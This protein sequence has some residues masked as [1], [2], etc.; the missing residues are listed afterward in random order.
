MNCIISIGRSA[1]AKLWTVHKNTAQHLKPHGLDELAQS[2]KLHATLIIVAC[3]TVAAFLIAPINGTQYLEEARNELDQLSAVLELAHDY[4][5][6][7]QSTLNKQSMRLLEDAMNVDIP[8]TTIID[9]APDFEFDTPAGPTLAVP[10]PQLANEEAAAKS[11]DEAAPTEHPPAPNDPPKHIETFEKQPDG[12]WRSKKGPGWKDGDR[13]AFL[14]D[15]YAKVWGTSLPFTTDAPFPGI[16]I[17]DCYQR[18]IEE[19]SSLEYPEDVAIF[20]PDSF[21]FAEKFRSL[22]AEVPNGKLTNWTI[23]GRVPPDSLSSQRPTLNVRVGAKLVCDF[24][25]GETK[26]QLCAQTRGEWR[27]GSCNSV[28]VKPFWAWAEERHPAAFQSIRVE[29]IVKRKVWLPK[30]RKVWSEFDKKSVD[31]VL[32]SL[33]ARITREAERMSLFG[34]SASAASAAIAFPLALSMLLIIN[35]IQMRYLASMSLANADK[36]KLTCQWFG[37]LPT[38]GAFYISTALTTG[39]PIAMFAL[40]AWFSRKYEDQKNFNILLALIL[41]A[42]GLAHGYALFKLRNV[43]NSPEAGT[44][45]GMGGESETNSTEDA[46]KVNRPNDRDIL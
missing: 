41:I 12:T 37:F 18:L 3:S 1:V 27:C 23:I 15:D 6:H 4:K 36:S 35:F 28:Q 40:L 30:T 45:L 16:T 24:Q 29:P 2:I 38:P 43:L 7:V 19:R 8:M 10:S 13:H 31:E 17:G 46:S 21:D 44:T 22:L 34:F 33:N 9:N 20:T 5:E 14:F 26:K 39:F 32:T 42:A 25:E 11:P